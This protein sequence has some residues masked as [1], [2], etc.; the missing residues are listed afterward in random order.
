MDAGLRGTRL[1]Q[2]LEPAVSQWQSDHLTNALTSFSGFFN[3]LEMNSLQQYYKTRAVHQI[4]NW[5]AHPLD[6]EG[7]TLQKRMQ[8][9]LEASPSLLPMYRL[10]AYVHQRLPLRA[11][12]SHL[13]VTIEKLDSTSRPYVQACALW[14]GILPLILPNLLQLTR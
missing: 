2:F 10:G 9:A 3:L 7:K 12:K 6:Q 4:E 5:S 13:S 11:T 1:K 8:D 14:S